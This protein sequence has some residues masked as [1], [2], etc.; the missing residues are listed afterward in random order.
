[1]TVTTRVRVLVVDDADESRDI[2]RRALA[3]DE[4]IE[5]VGEASSGTDAVRE[6]E[7]VQPDVILMDVR[8]P[9]GDGIEATREITRRF[10]DVRIL[11][12]T[13][14][15]DQ[16]SVRDMLAAG[17]TGYLVK[18]ASVDEVTSAIRK[19]SEGQAQI[20]Q[21]IV[22]H[23]LDDLRKLIQEERT[24]RAEAEHLAK[25]R[26][27]LIQVLSHE[28]RSPLTLINA[29]LKTL[30]A[31]ELPGDASELVG[32]AVKRSRQ[33]ERVIEGLELLAEGPPPKSWA[34]NPVEAVGRLLQTIPERPDQIEAT[35]ETWQGVHPDHLARVAIELVTNAYRHGDEPVFLRLFRDGSQG[36]VEVSDAGDF[37]PDPRLFGPFVQGDMSIRRETGGLGLGLFVVSRLCEMSGGWVD[38]R[39]D[40]GRTIAVARFGLKG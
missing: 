35:D 18:G 11:A 9:G 27:E 2:L 28:L 19:T 5:V 6:A 14:H 40:G 10:P 29:A 1:V 4:A 30:D 3:F 17:A 22:H 24:R 32:T 15:D 13:A 31:T 37:E 38:I 39:N 34:A 25:A 21:K 20:D 8:M 33:L 23:I 12:L 16:V 7:T 26:H 36:V